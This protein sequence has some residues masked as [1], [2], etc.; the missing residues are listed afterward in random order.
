MDGRTV[1]QLGCDQCATQEMVARRYIERMVG[2]ITN[3]TSSKC[4]SGKN[5]G[6]I[7]KMLHNPRVDKALALAKPRSGYMKVMLLPIRWKN[8]TLAWMESS[9][10]TF[11]KEHNGKL[12][13]RMKAGR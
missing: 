4:T 3:V 2:C 8:V 13:A 12:F 11:V 10:I 5:S 6:R 7:R 1:S 9:V